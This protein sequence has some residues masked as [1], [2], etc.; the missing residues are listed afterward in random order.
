MLA[1]PGVPGRWRKPDFDA[2]QDLVIPV[3][4]RVAERTLRFFSTISSLGSPQDITLQELHIEALHPADEA[5]EAFIR[6][7]AASLG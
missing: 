4:I 6:T 3:E 1:C 7:R 5:T 2:P